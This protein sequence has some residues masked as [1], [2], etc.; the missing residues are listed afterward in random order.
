[1]LLILASLC[2]TMGMVLRGSLGMALIGA[3]LILLAEHLK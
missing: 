1:M 3:G 2:L